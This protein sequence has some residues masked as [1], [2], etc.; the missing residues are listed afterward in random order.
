MPAMFELVGGGIGVMPDPADNPSGH[1]V[2]HQDAGVRISFEV[3][4][5]SAS[6]GQ[7]T[8]SVEV[9]DVFFADFTSNSLVPGER[10]VGFM[11]LGRLSPGEHT[12]LV[13][14]NP[15]SGAN[16]HESNTFTVN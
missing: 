6:S 1:T 12:V 10:Q 4:N 16:D 7:A 3:L 13:F 2:V 9:D 14:V 8:V 11:S 5:V 15:G